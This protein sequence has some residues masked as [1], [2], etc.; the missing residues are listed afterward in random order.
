MLL[1][2]LYLTYSDNVYNENND[3]FYA[4]D[5]ALLQALSN[6]ERVSNSL[7]FDT[8][9]KTI[10]AKGM[11][12]GGLNPVF[13]KVET[14]EGTPGTN[15]LS[16]TAYFVTSVSQDKFGQISYTYSYAYISLNLGQG[17]KRNDLGGAYITNFY[18]NDNGVLSYNYA[19][20][21]HTTSRKLIS[22]GIQAESHDTD[23]NIAQHGLFGHDY[24]VTGVDID[25]AGNLLYKIYDATNDNG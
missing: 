11:E 7:I 15:M 3:S 18:I 16:K 10:Y 14:G 6:D 12:F 1:K 23:V 22:K 25:K 9:R 13:I 17:T 2:H 20:V 21:N 24:I 5:S 8:N 19:E 4:I